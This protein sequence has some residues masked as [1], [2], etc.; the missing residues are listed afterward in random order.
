VVS[1]SEDASCAFGLLDNGVRSV[2]ANVVEAVDVVLT[3]LGKD[4]LEACYTMMQEVLS[5]APACP[6]Q[7]SSMHF[8]C[9][10]G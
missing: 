1:A 3:V 4:E 8:R 5:Q 6:W 9:L 2:T 10:C 7:V